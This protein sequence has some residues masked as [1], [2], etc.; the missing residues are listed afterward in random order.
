MDDNRIPR[1]SAELLEFREKRRIPGWNRGK[2][3]ALAMS[4]SSVQVSKYMYLQRE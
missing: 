3:T 4:V 1:D 2:P